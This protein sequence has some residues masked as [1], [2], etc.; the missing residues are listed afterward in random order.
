MIAPF[1][2]DVAPEP[3][4]DGAAEG[5]DARGWRS[6]GAGRSPASA[7]T[8]ASRVWVSDDG[9]AA[10]L[11]H[12]H[13]RARPARRRLGPDRRRGPARALG[14]RRDR[15]A[16][17]HG[18]RRRPP[19]VAARDRRA[20][21]RDRSRSCATPASSWPASAFSPVAGRPA[22]GDHPRADRRA[23]AG[24]LGRAHGRGP[25]PRRSTSPGR[26]EPVG[27][28]A[29]R[30]R[31]CCSCSWSRAGTGCTGTTSRRAPRRAL[32]TEPGSI[33]AA[34]VRPDGDGLVPR[35]QRRAPG[36]AARGRVVRRPLL[37]P[38]GPRA[39]AGRPFETWWFE[40]PQRPAR[41]RVPRAPRGRRSAPGDDA[42]PRRPALAGH[43]PLGA[44][45]PGARRRRVPRRDGQL[46]RLGGLRP[47]VAR[48]ADR[49]RRVP[50]ARGR[51]RRAWTTSSPAGSPTRRASCSP[52][53]RGAGTSRC[54][55]LGR[56]P[57]RW[58][59]RDRG[60]A[61]G[62]LR[63]RVRGR[64]ADPPGARPGAVRRLAGDGAGAVRGA[65]PDHV[66]GRGA[67]R[68]C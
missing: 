29:G 64:G 56:H 2:E 33:T 8:T 65:Q 12:E 68:R 24:D 27:L 20:D 14:G 42:G 3:L 1:D 46:P 19:P 41:P 51:P 13:P 54:S 37:E 25:R 34:A 6:G 62:G 17:G 49:Q 23:A 39:P 67:R 43:G 15:R 26:V 59:S 52:A 48:R 44:R 58:V 9:G 53:G 22:D 28:V 66:R 55:A 36:A 57:D 16:R 11:L 31:R 47:G 5:L 61:G 35:P 4:L 21:R 50:R 18:G 30:R 32:D 40:N 10:R 45:R 38:E 7:P 60:R 63:R